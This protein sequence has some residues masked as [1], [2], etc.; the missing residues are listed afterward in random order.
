MEANWK[1]INS[2][3]EQY[4]QNYSNVQKIMDAYVIKL[5]EIIVEEYAKLGQNIDLRKNEKGYSFMEI[6]SSIEFVGNFYKNFDESLYDSYNNI[7]YDP[8]RAVI[9][10]GDKINSRVKGNSL[11]LFLEQKTSDIFT[12]CHESAHAI[13]QPSFGTVISNGLVNK[14]IFS[15]INSITFERII[16]EQVEEKNLMLRQRVIEDFSKALAYIFIDWITNVYKKYTKIDNEIFWFELN[17]IDN[18]V[19]KNAYK[20]YVGQLM[21]I[22]Q[23]GKLYNQIVYSKYIIASTLSATLFKRIQ[24]GEISNKE[25]IKMMS[26]LNKIET[27]EEALNLLNLNYMK[28]DDIL[29]TVKKDYDS[30]CVELFESR[31][32]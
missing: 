2:N 8:N 25:Y 17:S 1:K 7:I 21:V 19:L 31:K 28:N 4:W 24:S 32:R 10:L 13:F 12:I 27:F 26:D 3:L 11:F 20:K 18:V 29:D 14:L 9:K 22:V 16:N 15:E 30:C 5:C 6:N 23:E